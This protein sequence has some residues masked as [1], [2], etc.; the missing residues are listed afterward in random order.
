MIRAARYSAA[1][2]SACLAGGCAGD[3]TSYYNRALE[4]NGEV[5]S[6]NRESGAESTPFPYDLADL[7]PA[8]RPDPKSDEAG[9]WYHMEKVERRIKTAGE[10]YRNREVN[11]YLASV[12]CRVTGSYCKDVRIYVIRAA[13]MNAS[14]A[15]NGMMSIRTGL[16]LRARNEA[17]LAAVIGHEAGHYLRQHSLQRLRDVIDKTNS[18]VFFNFILAA[19]G[20]PVA[21]DL[22]VLAALGDI[23]AY[24]RNHEREA[25]GY[26]LLLMSRAG[27]DPEEAWKIWDLTL[28]EMKATKDYEDRSQFLAS[29]PE[30]EERMAVLRKLAKSVKTDKT[31]DIGRERLREI[32]APIRAELIRDEL[33]ARR[34]DAFEVLLDQLI[35]DGDN[36]AELYYFKGEMRRLRAKD[37]DLEKA[38][39]FYAK[40]AQAPGTPPPGLKRS[41]GLVQ[42]KLGRIDAAKES[43]AAYLKD[44]P[45]APDAGIVR[46]LLKRPA[47]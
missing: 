28:R 37:D 13:G 34:F 7:S 18:L 30:P 11:A 20:I 14:M 40:A 27:Y 32:V 4:K 46:H 39:A 12:A 8:H 9:I 19:A 25:D 36:L 23:Q 41:A 35:A 17:Q 1:L 10:R 6:Q 29:H 15:P 2:L 44:N 43:F 33:N 3:D 47:K 26:G 21:G 38:L 24:G 16:L 31:T 5:V 22:A 45:Q 42:Y